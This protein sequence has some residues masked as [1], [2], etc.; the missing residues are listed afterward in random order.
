MSN[1]KAAPPAEEPS[2]AAPPPAKKKRLGLIL[3]VLGLVLGLGGGGGAYWY[4]VMR[5]APQEEAAPEPEKAGIVPMAPFVVNLADEGGGRFLRVTLAL[6]VEGEEHAK[7]V[8]EDAVLS[9]R[10]RSAILERLAQET[11]DHLV[12]PK[13]KAELKKVIAEQV[14]HAS[15]ELKVTD[16]LFSEFVVQF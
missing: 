10:L 9:A 15:H 8:E 3:A 16:V 14:S 6:T 11:A 12:T 13:G 1:A 5:G 2:A 7:E 4:F